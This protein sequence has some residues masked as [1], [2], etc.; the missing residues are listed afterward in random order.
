MWEK[1]VAPLSDKFRVIVPD[2]PGFGETPPP[3]APFATD[4]YVRFIEHVMDA[5]DIRVGAFAGIS[6]GGEICALLA[7]RAPQRVER[8]ALIAPTG[9]NPPAWMAVNDVRWT[10]ASFFAKHILLPSRTF[11]SV[12]GAKSFRDVRNRPAGFVETFRRQLTAEGK[13]DVFLQTVRNISS[14]RNGFREELRR[15]T[16]PSMIIWGADDRVVSPADAA[17]YQQEI[18]HSTLVMIRECGHSVPLEKPAELS[19]E[20]IKFV[21]ER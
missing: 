6:Y 17:H 16:S 9:F 14:T 12:N 20:I 7:S 19:D 21:G 13:R 1:V 18:H 11:L 10:V 8:L 4:D 15:I 2:L 3:P 5:I